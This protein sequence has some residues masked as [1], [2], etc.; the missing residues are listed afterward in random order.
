MVFIFGYVNHISLSMVGWSLRE[1]LII[2]REL[3]I[4]YMG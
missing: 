1:H 2:I 3:L 4:K